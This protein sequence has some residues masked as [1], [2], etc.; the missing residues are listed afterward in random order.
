MEEKKH[1]HHEDTLVDVFFKKISF[2]EKVY[3]YEY[4]AT[5]L[6]GG[7]NITN[8][9]ATVIEKIKNPYFQKKIEE[10]A[11][12]IQSGD[13]LNK[14]MKKMPYIFSQSE[15][16]IV[17]AWEQTGSL[18]NS[19]NTLAKQYKTLYELQL[20]VKSWLTYPFII[21]L[22]LFWA[23]GIV[24][25]YVIPKMIPLL[26]ETGAKLPFA[27]TSL[28]QVS[29]FVSKNFLIILIL[30]VLSILF[31][32]LYKTTAQGKKKID[33][34]LL[35]I[36]LIGAIYKN[37]LLTIIANIFWNLMHSGIPVVK[38]LIL[39]GKSCNN[40]IYEE[41]FETIA[42][43]VSQGN[44]IAQSFSEVDPD[45][46]FFPQSFIQM[47]TVGEKTASIYQICQKIEEQ[48]AR[49]VKY[50]LHKLTQWIEPIAILLAGMFV[51]WFA[52]AVYGSI[53]NII[54]S[55]G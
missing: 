39:V 21:F 12:Y 14:A 25:T 34:L 3:F 5:M 38:S 42:H 27:T 41:L 44:G 51:L 46:F 30:F 2:I 26:Q 53:L 33:S 35:T 37:Y 6:D 4:L 54:Q 17:E 19:L 29:M 48:Y 22:F 45:N 1:K 43:K 13:T 20:S 40:V 11:I 15:C 31:F 10:L 50:S 9:L 47:L 7:V 18:V 24:M 49:E 55:I 23:I 8:G 32:L 52:F 36:P 16:F 28:I